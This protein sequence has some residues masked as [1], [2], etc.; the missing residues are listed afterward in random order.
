MRVPDIAILLMRGSSDSMQL[1]P[2][3]HA[4]SLSPTEAIHT[5]R[6]LATRVEHVDR[7]GEVR[8]VAGVDISANDRTGLARAAVVVLSFPSLEEVEVAFAEEPL[9]MP[10]VPGL[11]SFREAPVILQ[12]FEHIRQVPDLLL[13]DGQGIAHPRRLGI[14]SHLGLALNMP[15]I[16]CAKS[17]FVGK[18]GPLA[19]EAGAHADL[20]DHGEVIGVA[21]RTKTRVKPM[22]I[23]QGHR[24]SLPTA[25]RYVMACCAG[26]RLPEPTRLAD[27]YSR[28]GNATRSAGSESGSQTQPPGMAE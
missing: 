25:I 11:L 15:S 7:L 14:A 26:Y 12:A 10:Y 9:R 16:G 27:K 20:V 6:E 17:I 23:S 1:P 4:W 13:V 8:F 18:H 24:I 3:L 19:E 21:L 5:Q 2:P 28:A 22:I